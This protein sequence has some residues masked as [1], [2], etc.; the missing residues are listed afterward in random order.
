MWAGLAFTPI[1]HAVFI[2]HPPHP[3][4]A[5][6]IKLLAVTRPRHVPYV[7]GR[8][9][10]LL[11]A[12]H[13]TPLPLTPVMIGSCH[14]R[15]RSHP[16]PGPHTSPACTTL[17]AVQSHP[18]RLS[19]GTVHSATGDGE[20][21]PQPRADREIRPLLSPLCGGESWIHCFTDEE[22]QQRDK[23]GGR[24]INRAAT[25]TGQRGRQATG[26]LHSAFPAAAARDGKPGPTPVPAGRIAGWLQT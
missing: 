12:C 11:L 15:F 14:S 10:T 24:G 9:P 17:A 20:R 4:S 19:S 22:E 21:H 13:D 3:A 18:S 8:I 5:R 7:N 6:R 2:P 23:R 16:S 26:P 1:T 25:A